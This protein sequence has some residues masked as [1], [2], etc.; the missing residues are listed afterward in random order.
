MRP[1]PAASLYRDQL[2]LNAHCIDFV[3]GG[4]YAWTYLSQAGVP[5]ADI[6]RILNAPAAS[7]CFKVRNIEAT[8]RAALKAAGMR[9]HIA[10]ASGGA[11]TL[12][13]Q[14]PFH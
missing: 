1:R 10:P 3:H 12:S 9:P 8:A 7:W 4:V 5:D 13:R 14:S 11:P 6:L 2:E